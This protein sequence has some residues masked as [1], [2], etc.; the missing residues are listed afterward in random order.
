MRLLTFIDDRWHDLVEHIVE[1]DD[2]TP[3][4][5]DRAAVEIMSSLEYEIDSEDE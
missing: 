3:G 5:D 4:E 1:C 2:M